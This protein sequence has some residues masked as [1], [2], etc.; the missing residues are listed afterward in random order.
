MYKMLINSSLKDKINDSLS[1]ILKS[2]LGQ[3]CDKEF[4]FEA[5]II[6]T[7][8]SKNILK[9]NLQEKFVA[10]NENKPIVLASYL[11]TRN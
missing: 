4:S 7:I 5:L 3:Y 8:D 11:N 6:I 9:Y 2:E 10:T 1:E